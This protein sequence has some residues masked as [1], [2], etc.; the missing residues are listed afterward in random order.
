MVNVMCYRGVR[1]AEERLVRSNHIFIRGTEANLAG[2]VISAMT[3]MFCKGS[4]PSALQTSAGWVFLVFSNPMFTLM[5]AAQKCGAF[6]ECSSSRLAV[7]SVLALVL[8]MALWGI[9]A[10]AITSAW[11][12]LRKI[13]G[14]RDQKNGN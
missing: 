2:I 14:R 13:T 4:D 1:K 5:R 11:L 3:L 12:S 8:N 10:V 6:Q 7:L 9:A